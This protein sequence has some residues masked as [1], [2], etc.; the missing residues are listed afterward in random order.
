MKGWWGRIETLS[1]EGQ[2]GVGETEGR[3]GAFFCLV[4]F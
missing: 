2:G 4:L 1:S 3:K